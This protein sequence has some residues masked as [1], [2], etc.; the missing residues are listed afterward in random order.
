[1]LVVFEVW[2]DAVLLL[3]RRDYLGF[4]DLRKWYHL[5]CFLLDLLKVFFLPLAQDIHFNLQ[6]HLN[7]INEAFDTGSSSAIVKLLV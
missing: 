4:V 1:M 6:V 2:A 3:D 7:F 5:L